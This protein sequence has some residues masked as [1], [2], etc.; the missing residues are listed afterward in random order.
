[1]D[2]H[3]PTPWAVA[4]DGSIVP[5]S[6]VNR[7]LGFSIDDNMGRNHYAQEIVP[8]L[9]DDRFGRGT[10][11]ANAAFIVKACNSHGEL[12][13]AL[14][15]CAELIELER[16]TKGCSGPGDH[17]DRH[18]DAEWSG[19]SEALSKARAALTKAES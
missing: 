1:M 12:V 3:T 16:G 13:A 17:K 14:E 11:R 19:S 2:S 6:H 7:A 8:V 10:A 15:D 4:W 5:G 18:A 9:D